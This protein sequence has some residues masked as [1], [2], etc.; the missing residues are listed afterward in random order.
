MPDFV[1]TAETDVDATPAKVWS[2]LTDP[3]QI[4]KFMFGSQVETDWQ[5]GSPIVWKGEYEGKAYEDK[6]EIVEVVTNKRLKVTHFSPLSGQ[7]DVPENY[8]NLTYELDDRDG[9]THLSLSQDRNASAE[10]AEHSQKMW[11]QM[12]DGVK[13]VVEG[14]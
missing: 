5:V 7:P 12:L 3:A 14:S 11:R 4:K 6:G 2:A 1:A 9:K 8:H 13:E 10:E